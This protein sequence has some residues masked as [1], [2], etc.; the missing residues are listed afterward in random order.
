VDVQQLA[1]GLWRWTA[2]HD[3]WKQAVG[4]VY[5][6][7]G[8]RVCLIDP[9]V[10]MDDAARFWRSL[11]RDVQRVGGVDVL[12]T[13]F[14]HSRSAREV[15][16]R[17]G[18]RL[19]AASRGR[20]AVERRTG[21]VTSPFRPGDVLPGGIEA[22]ASGRGTEVLFLL[23]EHRTLVTG[24]VLLGDGQGG[25]RLCPESWLPSGVGHAQVRETLQP[26]LE[27]E[28]ERVLVSHGEPI[29][30]GGRA[31]LEGALTP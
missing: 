25:L 20:V 17:Y 30:G 16:A 22:F 6:E 28:L 31:A 4:C 23:R 18:A 2:W 14:W 9:L 10:P 12:I 8:D 7:A 27:L 21:A 19:W 29:L 24:D 3:E 11:D 26:L 1:T 15:V 5:Y 13:V